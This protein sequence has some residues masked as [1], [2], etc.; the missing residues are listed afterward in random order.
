MAGSGLGQ[1]LSRPGP[2][3]WAAG[4]AYPSLVAKSWGERV[5]VGA[6]VVNLLDERRE[7]HGNGEPEWAGEDGST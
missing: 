4:T 7:E 5:S 6:L 1:A 3:V 2:R